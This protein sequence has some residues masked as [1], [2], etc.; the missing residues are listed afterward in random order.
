LPK[1]TLQEEEMWEE[2]W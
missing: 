1:E 2:M